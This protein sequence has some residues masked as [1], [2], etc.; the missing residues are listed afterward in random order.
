MKCLAKLAIGMIAFIGVFMIVTG[1]NAVVMAVD[2]TNTNTNAVCNGVQIAGGDCSVDA[3]TKVSSLLTKI[4]NIMS[5]I[6][7][8]ASII[9][10]ILGGLWFV[11]AGGSSEKVSKA[12]NTVLFALIGLVVVLIAQVLV[13]FVINKVG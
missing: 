6:V 12:R 7:G 2:S 5:W 9:V 3:N 13:R 10:I 4:I 1:S 11:T 8:I